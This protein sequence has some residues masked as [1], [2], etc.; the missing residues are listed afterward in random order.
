[1]F[2]QKKL[3]SLRKRIMKADQSLSVMGNMMLDYEMDAMTSD[4][5]KQLFD[6]L[7]LKG[8]GYPGASVK[9]LIKLIKSE[10]ASA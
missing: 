8:C 3:A 9:Y 5:R 2:D 4:E 7:F 10:Q 1:M 6:Y